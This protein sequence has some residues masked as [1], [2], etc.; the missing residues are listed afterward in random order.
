[1]A[2]R[3]ALLSTG[4]ALPYIYIYI[5]IYLYLLLVPNYHPQHLV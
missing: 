2:W 3:G 4:A 1:M 5:Y